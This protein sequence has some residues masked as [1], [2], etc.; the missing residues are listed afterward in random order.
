M[1]R[2]LGIL[3]LVI[4]NLLLPIIWP[5]AER[6][7]WLA[8]GTDFMGFGRGRAAATESRVEQMN[9]Q[10]GDVRDVLM[11]LAKTAG[12]NMIVDESVTGT[13]TAQLR[14][15][16]FEEALVLIT[17]TKGL[18]F[19]RRDGV[20]IVGSGEQLG[21]GFDELHILPLKYAG[22][23]DV[24]EVL[25]AAL[26]ERA[27]E[28]N[29]RLRVDTSRNIV[30]FWGTPAEKEQIE[31]LL[32]E[33]DAPPPQISLVARVVAIQRASSR[34]LGVD[35]S[36]DLLPKTA[37][38]GEPS[39]SVNPDGS[40]DYYP[41]TISRSSSLDRPGVIQFGRD[42]EGRP[43]EFYFQAKVNALVSSGNA[44][45]LARPQIMAIDGR[46]AKILI[47]DR[48]PVVTEKKNNRGDIT[49]STEY[50]DAGIKLTYTPRINTDGQI[51][52]IVHTE[53]SSPTLTP[54]LKAYRIT[55]REA[56][57]HVRMRDGETM[58]I[59][60]LIGSSET[61][62]LRGIPYLSDLPVLGW[63]FKSQNNAKDD[64][65]VVIFLTAKIIK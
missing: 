57:T 44:K 2:L 12:A 59:G 16:S 24:A 18:S 34:D 9:I 1:R 49:A 8:A 19:Q 61:K 26:R 36:W 4:F 58:V 21:K 46:E 47:G 39:K 55:T 51:T 28:K 50:I 45:I 64:T 7:P 56:Q 35:W 33:L 32:A 5:A 29:Q 40:V 37:D 27:G 63:L 25:G 31:R 53:V 38:Y 14:D 20:I 65:E 17:R 22:A 60:G 15:V 48:V 54:E 41:G 62:N 42:P 10:N 6:G 23:K 13:V 52:A 30:I 11:A 43:Y 3:T